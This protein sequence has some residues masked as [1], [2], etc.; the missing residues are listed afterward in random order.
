MVVAGSVNYTGAACLAAS[1]ATRVGAGLVTL[2]IVESLHPILASKLSETTFLLL[3]HEMGALVPEAVKPL[4]DGLVGYDALLLGPGLG[5]DRKT[6]EFVARLLGLAQDDKK[7]RLGF[8][9]PTAAGRDRER[10]LPPLVVDADGLNALAD[11][12]GWPEALPRPA[13]LT[14]HPGEMARLLGTTVADVK[15]RRIELARRAAQEWN[16]VVV[17][18]GAHTIIAA[19]PSERGGAAKGG[20]YINPFAS[21]ALATAGTGDV[22]AGTI[23]GLLAQGLSPF[24]AAIAGAYVHGLAGQMVSE[25]IGLAGAVAGDLLPKLP[26]SIRR[27][28]GP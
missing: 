28:A 3:P 5:R 12:E 8:L 16:A 14:P 17:L 10:Q 11:T 20:A 13:V 26:L 25:A 27:I 9:G 7:A 4:H 21:P 6:V 18:K 24:G 1:A 22:L 2:G 19:P 23:A 15:A